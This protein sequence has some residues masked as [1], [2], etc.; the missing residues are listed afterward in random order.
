MSVSL[1]DVVMAVSYGDASLV[2]ESAGYLILGAADT[3]LRAS[4]RGSL[5]SIT[6]DEEGSVHLRGT[7]VDEDEAEQA[8]RN[9]LGMLLQKVRIPS[10]N[11]ARVAVRRE[12]RGLRGLVAELEA[13]LVPVNRRAA[14]R[15]LARLCRESQK[16]AGREHVFAAVEEREPERAPASPPAQLLDV[17]PEPVSVQFAPSPVPIDAAMPIAA[18]LPTDGARAEQAVTMPARRSSQQ[19]TVPARMRPAMLDHLAGIYGA[20]TPVESAPPVEELQADAIP[21]PAYTMFDHQEAADA[22]FEIEVTDE[23]DEAETQVFAGVTPIAEFA[24]PELAIPESRSTFSNQLPVPQRRHAVGTRPHRVLSESD[25]LIA[26]SDSAPRRAASDITDLLNKMSV[27]PTSTED[28]YMGLKTLSRV[29]L[30]PTPPL[31][32]TT[33]V[34]EDRR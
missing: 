27:S 34:D 20:E 23:L 22:E 15:T 21:P 33:R 13:A 30:S 5:D 25:S 10:N 6:I 4:E 16:S 24:I 7:P 11:L 2:G 19:P 1:R 31:V 12:S 8:L 3:A 28:L 9:L 14:R 26:M 29:D 18:P 17:S 32:D